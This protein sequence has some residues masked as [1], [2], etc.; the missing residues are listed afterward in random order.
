MDAGTHFFDDR[1]N[2]KGKRAP[3]S[4]VRAFGIQWRTRPVP[5]E[6]VS[7]IAPTQLRAN[8]AA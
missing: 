8:V 6:S 2:L 7:A 1:I 3:I 4:E 5:R